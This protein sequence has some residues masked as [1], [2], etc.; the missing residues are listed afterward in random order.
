MFPVKSIGVIGGG[1]V[2]GSV[3]RIYAEFCEVMVFDTD[4]KRK[5][6]SIY[7]VLD[8]DLIFVCLPTPALADGTGLDTSALDDI[9]GSSYLRTLKAERRVSGK[10]EP[11][12]VIRSTVPVG[13]TRGAAERYDLR[14][15]VHSP[16]FLTARC[17]DVDSS[18]PQRMIVGHPNAP[19]FQPGESVYTRTLLARFPGVQVV[20]ML[21]D[22]SEAVKLFTNYCYAVKVSLF[23]ELEELSGKMGL[24][25][26]TV[27]DG[28]IG[29]GRVGD[30]HTAVPGHDG[31]GFGGACLVK[32][33]RE[34][35]MAAYRLGLEPLVGAGALTRNKHDRTRPV[36]ETGE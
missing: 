18:F 30:S 20:Q 29:G 28:I 2:G 6:H 19:W 17:A 9:L 5:T 33:A 32:D 16:E 25:W 24:D 7:S 31:N 23:N 26:E 13:Y 22:E 12:L 1:V 21:S 3:A 35:A 15:I 27:R 34:V 10:P 14:D 8:C 11:A 36:R 4:P